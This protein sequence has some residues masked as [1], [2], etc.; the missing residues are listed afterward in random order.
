MLGRGEFVAHIERNL[1]PSWPMPSGL[2]FV[3]VPTL[4]YQE[5]QPVDLGQVLFWSAVGAVGLYCLSEALTPGKKRQCSDCGSTRHTARSCPVTGPRR[6]FSSAVV[7][8]GWCECCGQWFS[9]TQ[10]HHW[11]GRADNSKD[12][13]MCHPCH[14][15]CGHNG[16]TRNRP[17]KPRY[18]RM[19]A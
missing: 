18:C 10:T 17:I 14:L 15:H 7:K 5:P 4:Y 11:G 9:S 6:G 16:H 1:I 19:A 3:P 12:M 13:E 8:T 2:R